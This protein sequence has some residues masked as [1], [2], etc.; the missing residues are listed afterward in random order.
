MSKSLAQGMDKLIARYAL[1]GLK[2]ERN[3]V[4]RAAVQ[5]FWPMPRA[6]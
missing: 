3:D 2:F 4:I 5:L 6:R 1:D